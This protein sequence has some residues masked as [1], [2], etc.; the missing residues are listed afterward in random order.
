MCSSTR[1]LG[2]CDYLIIGAGAASIAFIDTLLTELPSTKI[3]LI[4]KHDAPGG[5]W[6]D[7][8]DFV[9]LHQ[10]SLL[11]GAS[12]KQMEGNWLK[13]ML[14]RR[15]LPWNHRATKAE[16]LSYYKE[17]VGNWVAKGQV[18]FFSNCKYSFEQGADES[19]HDFSD[20]DGNT[21]YS[22]KVECKLVNGVLGECKVPSQYPV[23]FPVEE[24]VKI[25][26][27][28]ELFISHNDSRNGKAWQT[29][30]MPSPQKKYVVL[31]CGKTAM[32]TVVFLQ[33]KMDVHPDN[34]VWVIP[35]D[36]WMLN[37]VG[38]G[39]PWSYP[40]ALLKCGG[41][42][43]KACNYL[44]KKGVFSRLDSNVQPTRF[45]FPV[46]GKDEL[47]WMRKVKHTVRRGRVSSI[48]FDKN[49]DIIMNFGSQH[50]SERL[51]ASEGEYIFVHCTSPGPFNGNEI[52][53]LF[54]S[55]RQMNLSSLF[56]PPVPISMSCLAKLESARRK[57]TL[58]IDFGR[59]LVAECGLVGLD[60]LNNVSENEILN[61]LV[62]G[63]RFGSEGAGQ[64]DSI[65]ALAIFLCLL[66]VD[67]MD[68][69][70]WLSGNRL[71]FFSIPGFCC[72]VFEN[73]Q[74][75]INKRE[76]IG[77]SEEEA[78]GFALMATKLE[79]LEGK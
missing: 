39:G 60:D 16:I 33:S 18:Q 7:A 70:K 61:H 34:I 23:D 75:M 49:K 46:I 77:F 37:R 12:S 35:N 24:G 8:Y 42:K 6:N 27:P 5:H 65:K 13:C 19:I 2:S 15:T 3:V 78:R 45:R 73:L 72:R 21:N 32:D 57:H 54:V 58:D 30:I 9:R 69:Y 74:M 28:N 4:D 36:V 71:S 64:L 20:L 38:S 17:L 48:S 56:A 63:Y 76:E 66:N 29:A 79:P 59:E 40:Q 51:S 22:V 47:H 50:D 62:T 68:G 67:P 25:L 53:E 10:P 44:E 1:S 52:T 31:G 43:E 26:T 14:T 41:D 55:E 11:Y